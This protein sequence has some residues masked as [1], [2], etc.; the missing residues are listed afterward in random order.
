MDRWQAPFIEQTEHVSPRLQPD[1][2]P[3]T[4]RPGRSKSYPACILSSSNSKPGWSGNQRCHNVVKQ[5]HIQ[6]LSISACL[7]WKVRRSSHRVAV[8][9]AESASRQRR[10]S[11]GRSSSIPKDRSLASKSSSV[12]GLASE[13]STFPADCLRKVASLVRSFSAKRSRAT[14][15]NMS[16]PFLAERFTV[17]HFREF[18][19]TQTSPRRSCTNPTRYALQ[20]GRCITQSVLLCGACLRSLRQKSF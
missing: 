1:A 19:P 13:R 4:A 20:R 8:S 12:S 18:P 3:A 7:P 6:S 15:E 14:H 11:E 5:T 2:Q 17:D 10:S 16:S 9:W